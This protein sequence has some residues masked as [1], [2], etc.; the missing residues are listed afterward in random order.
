MSRLSKLVTWL[1]NEITKDD[2]DL[3][4]EKSKFISE[5]KSIKKE[6]LFRKEKLTLW[7]RIKKVFF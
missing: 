7:K 4:V 2:K 1:N 5:I 6:D 3:Q